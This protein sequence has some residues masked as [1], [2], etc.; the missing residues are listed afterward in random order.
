[1]AQR[2]ATGPEAYMAVCVTLHL[3][4]KCVGGSMIKS[5]DEA[6][7]AFAVVPAVDRANFGLTP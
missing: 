4:R 1:M 2:S 3:V 7:R 5:N 6:T